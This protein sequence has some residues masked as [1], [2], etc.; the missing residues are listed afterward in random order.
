MEPGRIFA[1]GTGGSMV[2]VRPLRAAL[3]VDDDEFDLSMT[4]ADCGCA[5][6]RGAREG[7]PAAADRSRAAPNGRLPQPRRNRY[8]LPPA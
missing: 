2:S 4:C 5:A 7:Q 1:V 8:P 6:C 3:A